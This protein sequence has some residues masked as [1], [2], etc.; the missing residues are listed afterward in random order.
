MRNKRRA[1]DSQMNKLVGLN[2]C[3]VII[4]LKVHKRVTMKSTIFCDV[5]PC[6]LGD[7]YQLFGRMN[8]TDL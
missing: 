1:A 6:N 8:C 7:V 5:A 2:K 4:S 3:A